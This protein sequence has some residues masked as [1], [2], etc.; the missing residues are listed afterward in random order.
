MY[1]NVPQIPGDPTAHHGGNRITFPDYG[2]DML[3]FHTHHTMGNSGMP[4]FRLEQEI[5]SLD[6]MREYLSKAIRMLMLLETK[7]QGWQQEECGRLCNL[8]KY[9]DCCALTII[10]SKQWHLRRWRIKALPDAELVL[11]LLKEMIE[12]GG[13]EIRNAED[14]LPLLEADS[15]LGWEPSM[16]YN[17][18][19]RNVK[20]KIRQTRQVIEH[21][22]P[23]I[24]AHV[25]KF[26]NR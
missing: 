8:A 10:H 17:G 15:R 7:L 18:G 22:I 12:I 24:I 4:Q 5:E 21:E 9:L 1:Q 6:K 13:N 19:V 14:A 3:F 20:W 25:E 16:E 26:I 2:S 11:R 23:A